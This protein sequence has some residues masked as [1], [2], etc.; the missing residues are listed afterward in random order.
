ME[1]CKRRYALK[2]IS[3]NYFEVIIDYE[4]LIIFKSHK[5]YVAEGYLK[6]KI[7][8]KTKYFHR[9]IMKAK[10]GQEIDHIDQ[11]KL[12]NKKSNLR[13]C[14][15]TE[16]MINVKRKN[17]SGFRGV[18]SH[19]SS[20]MA[21][22]KFKENGRKCLYGFKTKEEAAKAYDRMALKYHGIFAILNFPLEKKNENETNS[23]DLK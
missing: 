19:H 8:K 16:N 17:K 13:F 3:A 20:W 1:K 18:T 14:S 12:N 22:I 7:N 2:V 15:R 4:D 9:E 21:Q 6:A 10:E 5:W 11:N 23:G